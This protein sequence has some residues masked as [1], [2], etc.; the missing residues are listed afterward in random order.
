MRWNIWGA[1]PQGLGSGDMAGGSASDRA[2]QRTA[3]VLGTAG[4]ASLFRG[5]QVAC[6]SFGGF[7]A[8]PVLR[9][10]LFDSCDLTV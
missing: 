3:L 6:L 1:C 10:C 2:G 9:S 8:D 7:T 5:Q 4:S